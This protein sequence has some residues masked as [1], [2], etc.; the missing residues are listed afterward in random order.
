VPN[1]LGMPTQD[2]AS[3]G[4]INQIFDHLRQAVNTRIQ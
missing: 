4:V 1:L 3:F 2:M